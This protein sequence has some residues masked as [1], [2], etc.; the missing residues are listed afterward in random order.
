MNLNE[1]QQL[2]FHIYLFIHAVYI[3]LLVL[4]IGKY[5]LSIWGNFQLTSQCKISLHK[6]I[7]DGNTTKLMITIKICMIHKPPEVGTCYDRVHIYYWSTFLLQPASSVWNIV[8][9]IDTKPTPLP[10]NDIWFFSLQSTKNSFGQCTRTPAC[11]LL[12][13]YP[14]FTHRKRKKLIICT[15]IILH[16][17]IDINPLLW[18]SPNIRWVKKNSTTYCQNPGSNF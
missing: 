9:G 11:I 4:S 7:T 18:L 1:S 13:S 14:L 16:S 10:R 15:L 3:L 17:T 12:V 6:C 2:W 8:M 5:L